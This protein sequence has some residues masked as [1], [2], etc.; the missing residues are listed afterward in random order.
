MPKEPAV[1]ERLLVVEKLTAGY[2]GAPVIQQVDFQARRG[3]I[4]A[5]VGPNGAGKSTFLK[6]VVGVLRPQEGKVTFQGKDVTGMPAQRL[7]RE[8]ISY[9]PQVANVF[10]SLTV[11][12]NLEMGGFA[13]KR[14]LRGR[15]EHVCEMFPDLKPAFKRPARTLSG[16]QRTMLAIARGLML[17]PTVLIL[18]EPTAGLAPK[19]VDAVWSRITA[20]RSLDVAVVIV[21]Q[22]TRRTLT[23]ADW[24]YVMVLGRNRLSGTG[25]QLLDDPEVVDLYIGKE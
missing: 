16:G 22:N 25:K 19:F 9:I 23:H 6:V 3:H 24:G 15:I 1:D 12:E 20:I 5:I 11:K 14:G 18:D 10:P 13:L 21:E 17:E 4:T 8:G 2:G 7:V